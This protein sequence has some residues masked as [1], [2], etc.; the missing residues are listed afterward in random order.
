MTK[1]M[2]ILL[3]LLASKAMAQQ[4]VSETSVK[5]PEKASKLW[6]I[7]LSSTLETDSKPTGDVEKSYSNTTSLGF[8]Y[9][10]PNEFKAGLSLILDKDLEGEREQKLRDPSLSLSRALPVFAK[11]WTST[12]K[13]ST[14][15]PVSE[16][17]RKTTGLQTAL[18]A[19]VTFLYDA[20]NIAKGL[21]IGYS[22]SIIN[23]FHEYKVTT[24][25]K[26]NTQRTLSNSLMF[27]YAFNDSFGIYLGNTYYR[28]FTYDGNYNDFFSFDQSI[29]YSHEVGASATIGH[30]IGGSALAVN[31][32][33]SNVQLFDKNESTYYF[34]LG[35]RY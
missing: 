9:K 6:S 34:T 25:G 15:I 31:G 35:F 8:G 27:D 1:K 13:L 24:S 4:G 29:T 12:A 20:S 21:T 11:Y 14:K 7:S 26:S 23:N 5:S 17:S 18:S 28:N 16:A 22:P 33:E 2:S 19:S 30:A 32:K 3:I 10:L